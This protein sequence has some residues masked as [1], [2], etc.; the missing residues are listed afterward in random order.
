MFTMYAI[1]IGL[2]F[3]KEVHLCFLLVGH[4]HEDIDYKFSVISNILKRK[5]IDTLEEM[6]QLVEKGTS[7]TE[8]FVSAC[9]LEHV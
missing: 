6:L 7:Y 3:F 5:D 2:G 8:A 9:K 1:L 4:T